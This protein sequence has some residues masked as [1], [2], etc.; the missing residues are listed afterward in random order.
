[1]QSYS[2]NQTFRRCLPLAENT[3]SIYLFSYI[4]V[5]Q[6]QNIYFYLTTT[7]IC[8]RIDI[9]TIVVHDSRLYGIKLRVYKVVSDATNQASHDIRWIKIRGGRLAGDGGGEIKTVNPLRGSGFVTDREK[10]KEKN[11][12]GKFKLSVELDMSCSDTDTVSYSVCLFYK[13]WWV[14]LNDIIIICIHTASHNIYDPLWTS[15]T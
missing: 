11:Y 2:H 14:S 8:P 9:S 5:N 6:F 3:N 10:K 4:S 13:G 1:M 12:D 7:E 15:D